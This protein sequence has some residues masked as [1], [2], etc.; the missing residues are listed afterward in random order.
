MNG[1]NKY[2]QCWI[3]QLSQI[4]E[5]HPYSLVQTF[6]WNRSH[7][8]YRGQ[9][10]KKA[11]AQDLYIENKNRDL[12]ILPTIRTIA[13]YCRQG[14]MLGACIRCKRFYIA[15]RS[16]GKLGKQE[17]LR[18]S[19]SSKNNQ[20]P[21]KQLVYEVASLFLGSQ[22]KRHQSHL[23]MRFVCQVGKQNHDAPQAREGGVGKEDSQGR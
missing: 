23:G 14:H 12:K 18:A 22:V 11:A 19:T 16:Q 15:M 6:C 5:R 1:Q 4:N 8:S 20:T 7:H 17:I 10:G 2:V 21:E 9:S 13:G 3:E